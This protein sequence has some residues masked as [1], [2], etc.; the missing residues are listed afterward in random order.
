MVSLLPQGVARILSVS[1]SL[2]CLHKG[3]LT[4]ILMHYANNILFSQQILLQQSKKKSSQPLRRFLYS[5]VSSPAR[6]NSIFPTMITVVNKL[7][8]N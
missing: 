8:P 3:K 1:G 5:A 6:N 7:V 2:L 4:V